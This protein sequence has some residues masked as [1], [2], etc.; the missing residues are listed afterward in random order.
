LGEIVGDT[1]ENTVNQTYTKELESKVKLF[2]LSH[3]LIPDGI[4]GPRTI[5]ALNN[6][7]DA[8]LPKLSTTVME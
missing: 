5:I 2:Q 7:S 3:S 1:G 4:V 8:K 6:Q